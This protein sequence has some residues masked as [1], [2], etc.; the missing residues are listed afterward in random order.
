[1]KKA[2]LILILINIIFSSDIKAQNTFKPYF[3]LNT[4]GSLDFNLTNKGFVNNYKPS[5]GYQVELTYNFKKQWGVEGNFSSDYFDPKTDDGSLGSGLSGTSPSN[6]L[7]GAIGLRYYY[8]FWKEGKARIYSDLSIGVYH[9][10]PGDLHYKQT[11]IPAKDVTYTG[12]TQIGMNLGFGY[13]KFLSS[14][15]FLSS[16]FKYFQILS[17]SNV[18]YTRTDSQSGSVVIQ[19]IIADIPARQYIQA[20]IGLGLIF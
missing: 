1:M 17:A 2:L 16:Y 14:K 18:T 9:F 5:Y 8:K 13:N 19:K 15:I 4:S 12:Y 7:S 10:I 11:S 20:T 3:Q 6:Q